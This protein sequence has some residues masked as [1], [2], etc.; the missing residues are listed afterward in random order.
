[1]TTCSFPNVLFLLP[2][3]RVEIV[4]QTMYFSKKFINFE[5][6]EEMIVLNAERNRQ[7][8]DEIQ[9]K[10]QNHRG[11]YLRIGGGSKTSIDFP[12]TPA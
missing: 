12:S 11:L 7:R 4:L 10:F 1:M 2:P 3:A 5:E 9:E 8:F 6:S